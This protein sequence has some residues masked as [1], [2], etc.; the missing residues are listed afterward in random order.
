MY[1]KPIPRETST[2]CRWFLEGLKS[3][4]GWPFWGWPS[5]WWYCWGEGRED[6]KSAGLVSLPLLLSTLLSVSHVSFSWIDLS[7]TISCGLLA[8]NSILART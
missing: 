7:M 2:Y 8:T 3:T 4:R 1:S 6:P 5:W